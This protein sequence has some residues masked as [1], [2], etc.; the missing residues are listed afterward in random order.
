MRLIRTSSSRIEPSRR[1]GWALLVSCINL[2]LAVVACLTLSSLAFQPVEVWNKTYGGPYGDGIWSMQSTK[3]GGFVMAGFTGS[4]GKGSDLWILKVNDSGNELW[5]KAFGGSGEDIGYAVHESSDVGFIVAGASDSYGIGKERLWL[6][7]VDANGNKTWDRLFGGFVSSSGDGAWSV[8][9][10]KDAGF[11]VTGYTQSLGAEKDLWLIKTDSLGKKLWDYTFGGSK[12]DVGMS[13]VQTRDEG[14]V[15][16]GRTNSYGSGGADIWLLKVD[17]QGKELWNRTFGG[18]KDDVGLQV[19]E[20]EDGYAIVG[21]TESFGS[22]KKAILIKV[23][24]QGNKLWERTYDEN[25][26]GISLQTTPD[27]GFVIVGRSES[28]ESG[29]NALVI[30]TDSS[31]KK[32]WMMLL[33]GAGDDIGTYVALSPDFDYVLAGIT[34]SYGAGSEDAWLVKLAPLSEPLASRFRVP[35]ELTYPNINSTIIRPRK[36]AMNEIMYR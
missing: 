20:L 17:S 9:E 10:A 3:D 8:D 31:G 34:N 24:T 35:D 11:V 21:R 29:R 7:K 18:Q 23:D 12:D 27:H 33:G 6:L 25:T 16:A 14:Y 32:D 4:Y 28:E 5:N 2:V 15:I 13:L 30:K 1:T 22:T 19:I 26:A 36:M